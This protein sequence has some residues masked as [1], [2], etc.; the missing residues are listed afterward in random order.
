MVVLGHLLDALGKIVFV[1]ACVADMQEHHFLLIKIPY[2]S[3]K[4]NHIIHLGQ[5]RVNRF[6][7]LDD[8]VFFQPDIL[9]YRFFTLLHEQCTGRLR[10]PGIISTGSYPVGQCQHDTAIG[11]HPPAAVAILLKTFLLPSLQGL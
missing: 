10:S 6:A 5:F 11:L 7:K 9:I 4:A 3:A 8:V 1:D 2:H